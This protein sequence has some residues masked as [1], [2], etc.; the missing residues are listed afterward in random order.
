MN[1]EATLHNAIDTIEKSARVQAQIVDDV[2]DLSRIVSGKIHVESETTDVALVAA[3]ALDG[4]RLAA[5]AKEITLQSNVADVRDEAL[6]LGDANRLQQVIWNLLTNAIKFT[7]KGGR[8]TLIV[9]AGRDTVSMC[10]SDTGIGIRPDFLPHVFETFRQAE[11]ASTRAYGGLGLGLSIVRHLVQLH[12]GTVRA[13][14]D[15]PG[16]G[17]TFIVELPRLRQPR[18]SAVTN[19]MPPDDTLADL[20][21]VSVL[22]LDD[23]KAVRDYMAAVVAR[24]GAAVRTATDVQQAIWLVQDALPDVVLCDLAMPHADGFAFLQWLRSVPWPRAVPVIAVT[25]YARPEDEER[26]RAAGFNTFL[27]K[28]VQPGELS[29]AVAAL[30]RN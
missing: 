28:P 17:A 20:S 30:R 2:L 9:E 3:N 26:A 27:R 23:E 13:Q 12:G 29:Q 25:A 16:C 21:G 15:G 22:V 7:P 24:C 19:V 5:A 10:V 14:S 8:V 11:S 4:I 18:I 1:D 6:I